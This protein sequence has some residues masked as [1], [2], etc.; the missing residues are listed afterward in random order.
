MNAVIVT[1]GAGFIGSHTCK[2]LSRAGF[3]PVAVDDLSRGHRHNVRWG[4][5]EQCDVLDTQ[6]LTSVLAA[7]RPVAVLHFAG[8]AYVAESVAD[9]EIYYR[10]NVA[11]TLSLLAALKQTGL[12]HLV[13]SSS[14]AVY[15]SAGAAPL[16]EDTPRRPIS[17]YG[18]SKLMAERMIADHG[19]AH[20]RTWM[21]LR[22]FNAAGGDPDGE[23]G[24]EH[25]PEPHV[26]PRA[27]MAALGQCD[28]FAIH[29]T[30]HDTP[31][32]TCVRDYVHVSDI[33]DAHVAALRH[34][35]A[36]GEPGALNL[37][38]GR[39]ISVREIVAAAERVTGRPV[40]VREAPCRPGDP[41]FAIADATAARNVLGFTPHRS[42]LDDMVA[43]CAAW[44]RRLADKEL[45]I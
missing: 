39:G 27:V 28:V 42:R 16:T 26:I 45:V 3:L 14:C 37:G 1:G 10:V 17:P 30:D 22:Y 41:P 32:G 29:G 36:G 25:D 7:H 9:P 6:R 21:A 24:E 40:P 5:F 12:A 20:G 4:P 19:A 34:L 33:A 23:L 15:G 2:A 18:A 35:L 13:F 31:D 8:L 38:S 44:N 11:G 43:L